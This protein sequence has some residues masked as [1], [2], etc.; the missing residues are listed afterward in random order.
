MNAAKALGI[1][2]LGNDK[3]DSNQPDYQSLF[4]AVASKNPQAVFLGG[5]VSLHGGQL[6]KDKV[7]VLGDNSKVLLLGPDGFND[8]ATSTDAGDAAEGM[9]VT[10]GGQD[11]NALSN[12]AGKAFITDFKKTYKVDHLEAYTAYGAQ[13]YLVLANAIAQESN[14]SRALDR[15]EP[16]QPELHEGHHRVV[17]DRLRPATRRSAVSPSISTSAARARS[18]R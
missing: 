6:I 5:I 8:S 2:V 3:W 7:K 10:I 13:A 14:G 11:P 4:Q 9:Y 1:T 18:S 15:E 12:A 17:Q 16:L